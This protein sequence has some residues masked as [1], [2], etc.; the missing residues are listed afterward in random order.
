ML[1]P[2]RSS[3]RLRMRSLKKVPF[4]F[5]F[6][7]FPQ[8]VGNTQSWTFYPHCDPSLLCWKI[9]VLIIILKPR[10]EP[11]LWERIK[12][13]VSARHKQRQNRIFS[14]SLRNP[15]V[16]VKPRYFIVTCTT[17]TR[18]QKNTFDR[19]RLLCLFVVSLSDI[20]PS[21]RM[22]SYGGG[23]GFYYG[24]HYV[25][26][27]LNPQSLNV[28]SSPVIIKCEDVPRS[29]P[30]IKR[31]ELV[32]VSQ[33]K[34][35]SEAA[36]I[37]E[38][39]DTNEQGDDPS[40]HNGPEVDIMINNVVSSFNVRCHLNLRQIALNGVNVEYRRENGVSS[41]MTI[42][43]IFIKYEYLCFNYL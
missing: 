21:K 38:E 6:F 2:F 37:K 36:V 35:E 33:V 32:K 9:N 1:A 3:P 29:E 42:I 28:T 27:C 19:D 10:S 39:I 12:S 16:C 22:S 17:F 24:N 4:S 40:E 18:T 5:S 20:S 23:N 30:L 14:L 15:R 11:F 26:L 34:C 13:V 7:V 25:D 43:Y 41:F 31:E 8:T